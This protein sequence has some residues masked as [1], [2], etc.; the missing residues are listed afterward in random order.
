M[1]NGTAAIQTCLCVAI[2]S[3]KASEKTLENV[4]TEVLT[5]QSSGIF[6]KKLHLVHIVLLPPDSEHDAEE[7]RSKAKKFMA[8]RFLPILDKLPDSCD[9]ELHVLTITQPVLEGDTNRT[10]HSAKSKKLVAA[11]LCQRAKKLNA[12][13]LII[14]KHD[15]KEHGLSGKRLAEKVIKYSTIPGVKSLVGRA[16]FGAHDRLSDTGSSEVSSAAKSSEDSGPH[17]GQ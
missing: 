11:A 6:T 4:V 10:T 13:E 17:A 1:D 15:K 9:W 7:A 16:S 2:Q 5:W 14:N 8:K 12:T 3:D